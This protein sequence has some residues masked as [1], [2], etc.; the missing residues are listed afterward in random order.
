[1]GFGTPPTL[2]PIANVDVSRYILMFRYI[3]NFIL[4]ETSNSDNRKY[5][6]F[7]RN[8]WSVKVLQVV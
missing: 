1:M 4:L 3:Y 5:H 7:N 8:Y 6:F 2:L